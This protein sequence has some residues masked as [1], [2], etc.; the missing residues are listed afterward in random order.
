M[1]SY[2][3]LPASCPQQRLGSAG[4]IAEAMEVLDASVKLG[5]TVM[6]TWAFN[7]GAEKADGGSNWLP[8]QP[9]PGKQRL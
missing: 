3:R 2:C 5:L 4:N 8:I 9:Q 6:R 7:D 1:V